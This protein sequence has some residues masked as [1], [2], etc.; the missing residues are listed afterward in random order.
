M[1]HLQF[2][3]KRVEKN[4]VAA[5]RLQHENRPLRATVGA[6]TALSRVERYILRH[7]W[8]VLDSQPRAFHT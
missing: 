3:W 8:I 7:E 1:K 6:P 2:L 4:P 5:M